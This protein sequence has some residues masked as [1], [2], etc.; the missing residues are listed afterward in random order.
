MKY[1][2]FQDAI[3]NADIQTE[4]TCLPRSQAYF[5]TVAKALLGNTAKLYHVLN[6]IGNPIGDFIIK[7]RMFRCRCFDIY[8]LLLKSTVVETNS[9][10]EMA[11]TVF[12][13]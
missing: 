4:I 9:E 11:L 10:R 8:I 3:I 13:F 7:K 6:L 5:S 12:E 1:K 2:D